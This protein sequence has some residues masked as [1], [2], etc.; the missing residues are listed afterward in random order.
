M[1][2]WSS[3]AAEEVAAGADEVPVGMG[4]MPEGTMELV[5]TS[6]DGMLK[7]AVGPAEVVLETPVGTPDGSET[8]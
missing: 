6:E 1:G 2:Q 5:P 7:G 3:I 8:G 4:V